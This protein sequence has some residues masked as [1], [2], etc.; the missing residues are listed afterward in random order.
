MEQEL[1]KSLIHIQQNL[2]APKNQYNSFGKFKYR[3]LED[4]L[5]ALKPLLAE[6]NCGIRF[7]DAIVEHCGR[8]FLKT[9]LTLFNDN[10]ESITTTAEAEHAD[11]K[12]GMD[13]AQISGAASSYARKYALNA[14]F[15]I[16]DS[17]EIDSENYYGGGKSSGGKRTTTT[18]K[19]TPKQKPEIDKNERIKTAIN[20]TADLNSLLCLYQQHQQEVEANPEIKGMFSLRRQSLQNQ[21]RKRI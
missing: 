20:S 5:A 11:Q 2:N 9:T 14:L 6:Q 10:G 7:D 16:D 13:A 19:T 4:V 3:S 1:L 18:T 15:C 12:S 8:T 17:P 21:N